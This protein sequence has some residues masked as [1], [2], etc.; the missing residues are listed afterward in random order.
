MTKKLVIWLLACLIAPLAAGAAAADKSDF[1]AGVDYK[2][3][4]PAQP[5]D[6]NHI[7][8]IEMF[9]Y[10]CPHC[11]HFIPYVDKWL[12][13][14]PSNVDFELMPAVLRPSWE[15]HARFFY[16]AKA[17]GLLDKLHLKLFDAIHDEKRRL[18]TEQTLLDFVAEQGVDRKQFA[19][20]MHSFAV[21]LKVRRAMQLGHRFGVDGTPALIVDGK[22]R[23]EPGMNGAGFTRILQVVNYLVN[24]EEQH[25]SV[26]SR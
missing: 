8:V 11:H 1:Q 21:D 9:W 5:T 15:V 10:G 16:A 22:Y 25:R 2:L 18:F 4:R 13:T 17:L 23:V 3:I 7:Q 26:A 19:A 12:K 14:K 24:K 20:A 6:D